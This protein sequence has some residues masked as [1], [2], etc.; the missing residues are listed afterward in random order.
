MADEFI[1]VDVQGVD[2]LVKAIEQ[3]PKHTARYLDAAGKEASERV[4]LPTQGLK[5]YPP[6]TEANL[7]PTPYYIRG[8]G[9]QYKSKNTLTSERLGT[10]WYSR[11]ENGLNYAIG[12]P[13]SY[14]VYVHGDRQPAHMAAKG[15]RKLTEVAEEKKVQIVKVYDAWI[16]KLIEKV[17]L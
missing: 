1:T 7:P 4:I 12:N 3:F 17:G 10:K 16:G 2:K 5:R 13:V 6:A 14:A 11:S 8:K 15:W 9:T